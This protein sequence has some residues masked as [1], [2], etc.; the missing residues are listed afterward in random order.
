MPGWVRTGFLDPWGNGGRLDG[1]L[2][3]DE[4]A[5]VVRMLEQDTKS[6]KK[7]LELE[8]AGKLATAFEAWNA[9]FRHG[10]PAL[11]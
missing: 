11:G 1:Y 5:R 3:S 9:I 2:Q 6:A 8:D 7:A 10:F 4:R